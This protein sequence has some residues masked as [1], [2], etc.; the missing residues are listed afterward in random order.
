[1]ITKIP[2]EEIRGLAGE[3]AWFHAGRSLWEVRDESDAA[4]RFAAKGVEGA[5]R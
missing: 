3:R 2:R 4:G 5:L 1:M